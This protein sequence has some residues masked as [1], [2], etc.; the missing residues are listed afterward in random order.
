MEEDW[1]ATVA[2]VLV[3]VAITDISFKEVVVADVQAESNNAARITNLMLMVK[4]R[5]CM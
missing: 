3:A 2:W 4:N 5:L 1:V